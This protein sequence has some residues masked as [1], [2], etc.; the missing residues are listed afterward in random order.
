MASEF[1]GD[2]TFL[3]LGRDDTRALSSRP[4]RTSASSYPTHLGSFY[5]AQREED[6]GSGGSFRPS[7]LD[8]KI[9][10][11]LVLIAG[12]GSVRSDDQAAIDP[13]REVDMFACGPRAELHVDRLHLVYLSEHSG[14]SERRKASCSLLGSP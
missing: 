2:R 3:K 7:Y 14:R 9:H 5:K 8:D 6:K 4:Q 1:P 11:A 12:D 13:G 10:I